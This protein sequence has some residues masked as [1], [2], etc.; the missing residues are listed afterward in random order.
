MKFTI[1]KDKKGEYRWT[2]R[3]RNSKKIADC[4][5]GYKT[6]AHCKKMVKKIMEGVCRAKVICE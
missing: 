2:L 1:Y 3:A 5:E 6:L 4:A